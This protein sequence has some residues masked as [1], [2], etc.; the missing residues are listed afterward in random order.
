MSRAFKHCQHCTKRY[1]GCHSQC[2]YYNEDKEEWRKM[3]DY[4]D[5]DKE[6]RSYMDANIYRYL[7]IQ[8]KRYRDD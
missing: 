4:L 6:F 5:A 1:P 3:K 7:D 2:R 8:A